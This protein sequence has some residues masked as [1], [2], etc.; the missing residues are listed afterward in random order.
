MI[1]IFNLTVDD[2]T[3]IG[4]VLSLVG[5]A[6]AIA[7]LVVAL[8]QLKRTRDA[9]EASERATAR[10]ERALALNRLLVLTPLLDR[11]EH[12]LDLAI[13]A[14]D[15]AAAIRHLAEWR[16]TAG[17]I[18][19]L[20]FKNPHADEDL[21]AALRESVLQAA[22]AKGRLLDSR[23]SVAATTKNARDVIAGATQLVGEMSG[24]LQAQAP[25]EEDTA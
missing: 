25:E 23:T 16:T 19:G 24:R 20:I 18:Q 3:W 15:R 12:E 22:Q 5:L 10:T 1:T 17:P 11:V 2:A 4:L 13:A 7:G 6:L 14:D 8:R 9:V 21:R